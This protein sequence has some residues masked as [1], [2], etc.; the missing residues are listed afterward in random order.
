MNFSS[1][2]TRRVCNITIGIGTHTIGFSRTICIYSNVQ[3]F[4]FIA[5]RF[6]AF[7]LSNIVLGSFDVCTLVA[8]RPH[9]LFLVSPVFESVFLEIFFPQRNHWL[10]WKVKMRKYIG[11]IS[12]LKMWNFG[13]NKT[14]KELEKRIDTLQCIFDSYSRK[15]EAYKIS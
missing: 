12:K 15:E 13:G 7:R 11:H 10:V 14:W 2:F 3:H 4:T 8:I 9:A 1:P 5:L 6:H